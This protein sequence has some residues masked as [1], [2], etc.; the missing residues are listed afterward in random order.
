MVLEVSST[1]ERL[2][3]LTTGDEDGCWVQKRERLHEK[4]RRRP[5]WMVWSTPQIFF[6][7]EALCIPTGG[8]KGFFV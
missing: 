3:R 2:R 4:T 6:F 8:M 7:P 5:K 1:I